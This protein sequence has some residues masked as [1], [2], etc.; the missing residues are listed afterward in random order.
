MGKW[1]RE[2]G[3]KLRRAFRRV[4]HCAIEAFMKSNIDMTTGNLWKQIF[5]FSI[6]L[7]LSNLLQVLFNLSD[8]AVVGQFVGASAL[9]AVGS[10]SILVTLFTGICIG[11]GGGINVLV[12]RYIGAKDDARL[13]KTEHTAF[14]TCIVL[15][16]VLLLVGVIFA[17]P[18]LELLGTKDTLI[19]DATR[20]FRIYMSGMIG[21]AVYNFGNAVYSALGNTKKPLIFLSVSGALNIGLNIFFV[22]KCEMGVAGVAVASSIS[23]YLSMILIIVSLF[24][25]S[26]NCALKI[27]ELKVDFKS[28]KQIIYLG[29]PAAFQNALF[30]LANLFIQ[31]AVNTFDE[32]MVDGNSAAA[33]FDSI[34]Y[35]VMAAFYMAGASF[36]GQ[37]Y[38]A[39]NKGRIL[40]AYLIST[41]YAFCI[42]AVFGAVLFF[43]GRGCLRI[44]TRD[45]EVIEMGMKRIMIMAPSY[46]V[47]AFMDSTIAACRG[48][49]KTVTPIVFEIIGVCVFRVA[50]VYTVFAYFKTIPSLYLLYVFSWVIT[51]AGEIIYFAVQYKKLGDKKDEIIN[52]RASV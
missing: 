3:Q 51:A 48:I 45:E 49:G 42:A 32:V 34:V 39:N 9:G 15:G 44:F 2:N 7:V 29:V 23:Q 52:D 43:F 16:A 25:R 12:A 14:I 13:K 8:M 20:Y 4:F 30:A 18:I 40:R 37:N 31:S 33:N 19:D 35:D 38:G 22:T 41:L 17:R 24:R 47:S 5:F 11:F 50:W 27:K 1:A 6:P 36:V 10:T 26:D 28:L 46:C 21:C